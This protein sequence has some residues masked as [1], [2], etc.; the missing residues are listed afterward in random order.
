[1]QVRTILDM[2]YP[3][4]CS[5]FHW[6]FCDLRSTQA[7]EKRMGLWHKFGDLVCWSVL[8]LCH[9]CTSWIVCN[10]QILLSSIWPCSAVLSLW[11]LPI[12]LYSSTGK[13]LVFLF[14]PLNCELWLWIISYKKN[15]RFKE[16]PF[17]SK[18]LKEI[19]SLAVNLINVHWQRGENKS[20]NFSRAFLWCW[21][22]QEQKN[23]CEIVL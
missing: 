3:N 9:D 10:P 1:M 4:I 18:P 6:H 12:C 8:W 11:L 7:E 22:N 19:S 13:F 23:I 20:K 17:S 21:T 5:S 16:G 14:C 15:P 2:H